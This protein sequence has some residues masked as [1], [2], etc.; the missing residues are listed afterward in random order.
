MSLIINMLKDLE[1]R[2]GNSSNTPPIA[3]QHQGNYKRHRPGVNKKIVIAI[4][5][6]ILLAVVVIFT[7]SKIKLTTPLQQFPEYNNTASKEDDTLVNTPW[8]NEAS[9]KNISVEV[10]NNATTLSLEIDH[11]VIYELQQ[12]DNI[13]RLVMNKASVNDGILPLSYNTSGIENIS[14]DDVDDLTA[15]TFTLMPGT[16]LLSGNMTDNKA[17][18]KIMLSFINEPIPVEETPKVSNPISHFKKP[19]LSTLIIEKYRSAVQQASLGKQDEAIQILQ[20]LINSYP[21]Y[22]D[23]RVSLSAIMLGK[24]DKVTADKLINEGLV[25][26]P[27]NLSLIELKA[28]LLATDGKLSEAIAL[29]KHEQPSITEYPEYHA[30]IAALFNQDSKYDLAAQIYSKLVRLDPTQAGWWFG[31][32]ISQDKLGHTKQA[33]F[34]YT[35]AA[36]EGS[37]DQSSLSFLQQRLAALQEG[38]PYAKE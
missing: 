18:N 7:A 32:G 36:T 34:A 10:N 6:L 25:I 33:V 21:G 11:P 30:F 23:A 19:T 1:K 24:G 26:D 5:S 17:D 14:I 2:Q 12:T 35:K 27:H 28:R 4:V 3:S 20:G 31:L 22:Q 15:V 9:I 38:E 16:R 37:L 13:V 29:L 8:T